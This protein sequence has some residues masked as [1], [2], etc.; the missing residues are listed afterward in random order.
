MVSNEEKPKQNF[1]FIPEGGVTGGLFRSIDWT[2]NYLGPV[3]QWPSTLK[4]MLGVIFSSRHPMFIFWGPELI[5]FYNDAYMP[6]IAIGKHPKA[7]GQKGRECWPEIWEAIGPQ[8]EAVMKR[9]ESTWFENQLLPIKR[10]GVLED[11]YWTYGY[12]PIFNPDGSIGGTLVVCTETTLAIKAQNELKHTKEQLEKAISVA[13]IGFY[14]W[15]IANNIVTY[16]EQMKNDWD[17]SNNS[18]LETAI[19]SVHPED[20]KTLQMLIGEAMKTQLPFSTEYRVI[21]KDGTIIWVEAQGEVTYDEDNNPIRFFGTSLNISEKAS[22]KVKLESTQKELE[23][24]V[25]NLETERDMRERFVLALSHDLRT[26]MTASKLTAQLLKRKYID[27]E[28]MKVSDRIIMN[29][30]RADSMIRD[31]L[32]ANLIK[33]G[34]PLPIY[35]EECWIDDVID[36]T[37]SDLVAVHG[38]RF[39]IQNEAGKVQGHWDA[40]AIQ[41][42]LDN[43][44]ANAIKYGAPGSFVTIG[45]KKEQDWV[46]LSVHNQGEPIS[47]KDQKSLFTPYRRTLSAR[48]GGQR[49]WGIGLTLVKGIAEAHRGSVRVLSNALEGTT[50]TVRL[51]IN[52]RSVT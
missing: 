30:D 5:Q 2:K 27:P 36:S 43:L 40:N 25:H 22:E 15:D 16:S 33:A 23:T 32:D 1:S 17:I 52:S 20:R 47:P 10:N 34:D 4:T 29:M 41:R 13:K 18:P 31:L 8:I 19:N 42:L 9:G 51:P 49:G 3:E 12:S 46:E 44:N 38:P 14:D 37:V 50:F 7:M 45:L 35:L 48:S 26:P 39:K 24:T 11:V 21:R 28:I 6:S